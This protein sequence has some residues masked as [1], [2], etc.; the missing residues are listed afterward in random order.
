MEASPKR[1]FFNPQRKQSSTRKLEIV[2]PVPFDYKVN[3]DTD[4]KN[5]LNR[6]KADLDDMLDGG[7]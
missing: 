5:D 6:F 4:F 2:M 7:E 3:T 1:Q